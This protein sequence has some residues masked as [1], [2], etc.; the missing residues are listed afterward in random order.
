MT[1][2]ILK[3]EDEDA[4]F[5]AKLITNL[6]RR[7]ENDPSD[8]AVSE[9][10][11]VA[12]RL[13]EQFVEGLPTELQFLRAVEQ[14]EIDKGNAAARA[15]AKKRELL[16]AKGIRLGSSDTAQKPSSEAATKPAKAKEVQPCSEHNN[17]GARAP[18]SDCKGCW[19]YYRFLH[20]ERYKEA[21]K[22]HKAKSQS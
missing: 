11:M 21:W 3:L 6:H 20:P 5:L 16:K 10:L 14:K 15:R 13:H 4:D 18:R 8:P 9:H 7:L 2:R 22:K 17:S 1:T 12:H 19:K